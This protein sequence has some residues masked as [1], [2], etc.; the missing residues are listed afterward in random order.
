MEKAKKLIAKEEKRQRKNCFSSTSNIK[1]IRK[2]E[3]HQ[4]SNIIFA[5]FL[6]ASFKKMCRNDNY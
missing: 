3:E 1:L 2:T 4:F 5:F 6:I